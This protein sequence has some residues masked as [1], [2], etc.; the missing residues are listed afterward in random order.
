MMEKMRNRKKRK[1]FTLIELIVVI[2][3]LGI[4][5]AIAVPRF[6]G[7]RHE[8]T[9]KAEG[10]TAASLISAARVSEASDGE[11]ITKVAD[12]DDK[13][14]VVTDGMKSMY[15]IAKDATSGLYEITWKTLAKGDYDGAEQKLIEGE[16]FTPTKK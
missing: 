10:S 7:M 13:Y 14:M 1:G 9:V 5:A 2:A 8:A 4:L 11:A 3:I 12:I 6:T 16:A 15:T